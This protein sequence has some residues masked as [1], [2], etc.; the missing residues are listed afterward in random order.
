MGLKH[1]GKDA[2]IT[3]HIHIENICI[4]F[5]GLVKGPPNCSYFGR[6]QTNKNCVLGT[7]KLPKVDGYSY[8]FGIKLE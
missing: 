7:S 3:I 6:C 1:G 2:S 5:F 8:Q 4:L